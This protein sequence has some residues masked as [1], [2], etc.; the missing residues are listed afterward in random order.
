MDEHAPES[1]QVSGLPH[2]S[3]IAP[4][5]TVVRNYE[6]SL[7]EDLDA[8]L[9][10]NHSLVTVPKKSTVSDKYKELE[11]NDPLLK[12]NPRRWVMFPLQYPEASRVAHDFGGY[13]KRSF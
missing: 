8:V 2:Q 9:D 6:V 13:Q 3:L 7:P 12:E 5:G 11:K 10:S 1:Y 4:D